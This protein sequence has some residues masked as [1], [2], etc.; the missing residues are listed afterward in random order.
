MTTR[1]YLDARL[2]SN[3]YDLN[4]KVKNILTEF[5]AT[6]VRTAN[7]FGWRNQPQVYTFSFRHKNDISTEECIAEI[8][9]RLPDCKVLIHWNNK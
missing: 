2:N 6:N 9:K 5:W 4:K 7:K 3:G 1:Y 8:E